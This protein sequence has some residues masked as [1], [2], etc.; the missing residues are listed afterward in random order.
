LE[1]VL[2]VWRRMHAGSIRYTGRELAGSML[3]TK[4]SDLG[5]AFRFLQYQL[6][7]DFQEV[8]CLGPSRY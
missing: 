7:E 3:A 2:R 6:F 4:V 5:T 1:D 8:K